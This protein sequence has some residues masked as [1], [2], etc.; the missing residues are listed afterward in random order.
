MLSEIHNIAVI[1]AGLMGHGIALDCARFGYSV[2]LH[3][4]NAQSLSRALDNI[5][6]G[7]EILVEEGVLAEAQAE[8]VLPR[9]RSCTELEVAVSDADFVIEAVSE[10]LAVKQDL[11]RTLDALCPP[12]TILASSTSTFMPTVLA[13]VTERRDRVIVAHYFN[14]PY[15]LPLVE[16]VCGS[17]TSQQTMDDTNDLLVSMKKQVVRLRKEVPGFIGNRLQMALLREAMSLLEDGVATALDVDTVIRCGF[18]RRL[19][20]AGI[21]EVFDFGNW[22]LIF[23]IA[24]TLL[25]EISSET[26]PPGLLQH[27]IELGELGVSSGKGFYDWSAASALVRKRQIARALAVIANIDAEE[28]EL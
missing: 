12:R 24:R 27:K 22:S 5:K 19:A 6:Q 3:D 17:E 13:S 25:P 14:P 16:V 9:I 23:E 1:G 20:A 18:G 2:S 11:F 4:A 10:D 15:L 8:D 21:F 28:P 26:E 7:L